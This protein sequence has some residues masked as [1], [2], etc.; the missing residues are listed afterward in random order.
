M[1]SA[2]ER[3]SGPSPLVVKATAP[4][5]WA[6]A[7]RPWFP[8][9]AVVHHRGRKSGKWYATPVAIIPTRS[10]V[11]FLIGLPWGRSTNWA[12]NV[13]AA[14]GATLTWKGRDVTATNP[15][16]IGPEI[17]VEQA[18]PI[19]RRLVGGGRFPVFLQLD[20]PQP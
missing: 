15:R 17:A 3:R 9:W 2:P 5:A 7:G 18:K 8:L 10:N 20:R 13:L 16:L 1:G 19:M 6:L 14:D 11:T 12:Q 4:F